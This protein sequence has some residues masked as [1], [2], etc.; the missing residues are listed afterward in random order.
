MNGQS[1]AKPLSEKSYEEGSTTI[2]E[3]ST[4]E[5]LGN[6]SY[7]ENYV[8]IYTLEDPRNNEIRY[9]GKTNNINI[10]YSN[11]KVEKHNTHKCNWI[12]VLKRNNLVPIIEVL[13]IIKES[14]WRFWERYYISLFKSWGFRL[15]NKTEGGDDCSQLGDIR[16]SVTCYNLD[17]SL[18]KEYKSLIEASKDINGTSGHI[19]WVA[20]SKLR[21]YKNKVWRCGNDSFNKHPITH[22][23]RKS[24]LQYDLNNNFIKERSSI[25]DIAKF[26]RCT[27]SSISAVLRGIKPKYKNYKFLYKDIV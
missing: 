14:E 24:V 20:K 11:H 21:T 7:I 9:I 16:K 13:D 5:I 17:G 18:Y 6:G 15:T 12:R 3:G 25:V 10:R 4:S 23:S 22:Q 26:Y 1:A 8:Y 19:S 27:E 2:P